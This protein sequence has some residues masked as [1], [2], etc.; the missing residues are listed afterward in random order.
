MNEWISDLQ[1]R[2]AACS[3][4]N[5][6]EAMKAYM[7]GQFEFAGI[8]SPLRKSVVGEWL[9]SRGPVPAGLLEQTVL[10]LWELPEREFQYAAL[11]VLAKQVRRLDERHLEML[12]SLVVTKPWWDTVDVIAASLIGPILLRDPLLA[13]MRTELWITSDD[14]WLQRTA[15]LFQLKYKRNTDEDRLFDY[16]RRTAES[17]EF[18]IRKAIGWALR[19]YSK[20]D[21]GAVIRFVESEPLSPLSRRE[22]LKWL[23]RRRSGIVPETNGQPNSH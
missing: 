21:P 13:P 9:S 20:T 12:E 17:R 4:R 2:F 15:L 18:F 8:K 7:R 6:A 16:I 23:D 1:A 10:G 11:D 5:E 3:N 19:E 22:A 14:M